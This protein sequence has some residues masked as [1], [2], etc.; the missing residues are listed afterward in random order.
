LL[1]VDNGPSVYIIHI[2]ECPKAAPTAKAPLT[3]NT[4]AYTV[5]RNAYAYN[6]EQSSGRMEEKI[7]IH[8]L[9]DAFG[10]S[11]LRN[12]IEP[13]VCIVTNLRVRV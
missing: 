5:Y 2:L 11:G 4:C 13:Q 12:G 1:G 9:S 8:S 10:V 3:K 7:C 6:Q